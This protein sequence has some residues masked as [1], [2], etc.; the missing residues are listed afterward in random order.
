MKYI[1]GFF[2]TESNLISNQGLFHTDALSFQS[3]RASFNYL[4]RHI[5]PK[6]IY[7]PFYCC[8]ALVEPILLN[9][10]N[11]EWYSVSEN[12]LPKKEIFLG[13]G[14]FI[15]YINYFGI[16]NHNIDILYQR[17]GKSLILDNT[18][19]FFD[20]QYENC[21]S[22]NSVRKFFGLPDGAYL[23]GLNKG[24]EYECLFRNTN[25][26]VKYLEM[27][28]AGRQ[29]EAFKLFLEY[30]AQ[31]NSYLLRES[32]FSANILERLNYESIAA[33]RRKNYNLYHSVLEKYNLLKPTLSEKSIPH[34]YPFISAKGVS[35]DMLIEAGIFIPSFWPD[36]LTR[37][38]NGFEYEKKLAKYLLPLP[39]DHRYAESDC[40]IV[41]EKL[42]NILQV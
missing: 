24:N 16:Y 3:G 11:F 1:G 31:I 22:F 28:S 30:E 40:R 39:L 4:I 29:D 14:E 37:N 33:I 2:E 5:I 35:R 42:M 36:V 13:E 34:Y 8:D 19:A 38:L 9:N 21:F 12:L 32:D 27:R 23:Y 18:Q 15:I 6:K 17:Y 25:I 10:I 7:I 20:K 41:I 26:S